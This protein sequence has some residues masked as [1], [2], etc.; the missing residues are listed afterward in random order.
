MLCLY[1]GDAG[2]NRICPRQNP[3]L[4][5]RPSTARK[6]GVQS[7]NV[8]FWEDRCVGWGS[9]DLARPK[10]HARRRFT[11]ARKMLEHT[12]NLTLLTIIK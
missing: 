5:G 10:H 4:R 2:L 8:R 1:R 7:N 6:R 12:L 3:V 9:I 11:A